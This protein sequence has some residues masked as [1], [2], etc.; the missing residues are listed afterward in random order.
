MF[1]IELDYVEKLVVK[2]LIT[3]SAYVLESSGLN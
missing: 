3:F 2:A 1:I